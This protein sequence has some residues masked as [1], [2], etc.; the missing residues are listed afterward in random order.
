MMHPGIWPMLTM[1]ANMPIGQYADALLTYTDGQA[2]DV[3]DG[4]TQTLHIY[5]L[6]LEDYQV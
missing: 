2:K 6:P 5:C 3:N 1:L 4:E